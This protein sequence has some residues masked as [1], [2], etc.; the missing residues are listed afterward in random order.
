M[1]KK[2]KKK[3]NKGKPKIEIGYYVVAYI[4]LLGQQDRLRTLTGLPD[5]EDPKAMESF[6]TTLNQTYGVVLEMRKFF[7]ECFKTFTKRSADIKQLNPEQKK[8]F[9]KMQGKIQYQYFSDAI[10]IYV[11]LQLTNTHKVPARGIFGVLGAVGATFLFLL[12]N[13]HAIRGGIDL[14]IATEPSKRE[15]Y[16]PALARAYHLES[17]IAK[18]PRIILGSELISYLKIGVKKAGDDIF[19]QAQD[20]ISNNCLELIAQDIDGYA[21]LDYLG[22][23]F[24]E[25]VADLYPGIVS[26]AYKQ[27]L[28]ISEEFKKTNNTT[29]AFRYALLRNYF[30][31]RLPLWEANNQSEA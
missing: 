29:L 15:I 5:V 30:E 8:Q 4:D 27:V 7:N 13:G 26:D 23:G 6:K 24:K 14:G 20:K 17:R 1:G 3:R 10:A 31:S 9:Q 12:S 2:K 11:P 18:Y 16:G 21:F 22:L 25:Y 19:E 28:S